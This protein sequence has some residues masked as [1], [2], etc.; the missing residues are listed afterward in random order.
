MPGV[1][2]RE[3]EVLDRRDADED[4]EGA[5]GDDDAPERRRGGRGQDD[6][7]P[8]DV[9]TPQDRTEQRHDQQGQA[10]VARHV[11]IGRIDEKPDPDGRGKRAAR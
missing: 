11:V 8:G 7:A 1:D 9:P 2:D 3:D 10:E 4:L 5:D 6:H